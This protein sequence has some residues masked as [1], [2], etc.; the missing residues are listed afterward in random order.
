MSQLKEIKVALNRNEYGYHNIP[1]QKNIVN[2]EHSPRL[3]IGDTLG[4]VVVYWMLAQN[5]IDPQKKLSETRH[6]STIGS[7]IGRGKCDITVWGSGTLKNEID[8]QKN[9]NSRLKRHRLLYHRKMDFRAVRGPYT[10]EIVLESGYQCPEIYGDPAVLMPYIYSPQNITKK[11]PVSII[12]HHRTQMTDSNSN[13]K[14]DLYIDPELIN[15][16]NIHFIDPKTD[17]YQ[18]FI[19]E[20]AASNYVISSSLHG[21]ILAESYGV[22]AVFLNWGMDDQ[23]IKFMDWYA[24]TGRD[25][26]FCETVEKALNSPL[27]ELPDLSSMQNAMMNTFPYDLWEA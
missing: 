6:L 20:L 4:P 19:N 11:Y 27:P 16:K 25:M 24:S 5:N 14:Y 17:D 21:I 13:N 26:V 18:F 3:N 1:S 7:V 15:S 12:L 22:P 10:R 23:P 9:L 2:I 8:L